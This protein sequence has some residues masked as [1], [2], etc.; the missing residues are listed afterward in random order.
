MKP[1]IKVLL[2]IL[3]LV[4]LSHCEKDPIEQLP[5]PDDIVN[6]PDAEFLYALINEGVDTNGDVKISYAEAEQITSLDFGGPIINDGMSSE[7]R[8]KVTCIKGIEAFKNLDTLIC[9]GNNI[10]GFLDLSKNTSLKYLDC[11]HNGVV[12]AFGIVDTIGISGLDISTCSELTYLDCGKNDLESLDISNN[13]ALISLYC[14]ANQLEN[15]DVSNNINLKTLDCRTNN[16]NTLN[17]LKNT[18]LTYLS[19]N[20]TGLSSLDVSNNTALTFLGCGQNQLTYLDLSNNPNLI[21]L[22][23]GNPW[24]GGNNITE[25][26]LSN[27]NKLKGISLTNMPSLSEVCVWT[28]PF[29]P[30]GVLVNTEGSPNVYFTTDCS[31]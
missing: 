13:T 2:F 11:Y 25:L 3:A 1:I 24:L 4:I 12:G 15:L 14:Q 8:G 28:M 7:G 9:R 18:A 21:E 6:I 27:N 17:V 20:K 22:D 31:K 5:N 26:D 29:P 16:F 30:E 10:D 19:C 23:C